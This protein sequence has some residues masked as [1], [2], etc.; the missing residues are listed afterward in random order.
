[1]NYLQ[2]VS[3]YFF[4]RRNVG[5]HKIGEYWPHLRWWRSGAQRYSRTV[6]THGYIVSTF[7][8]PTRSSFRLE[9]CPK[10]TE[11]YRLPL[12]KDRP[13]QPFSFVLAGNLL[14]LLLLRSNISALA[15]IARLRPRR[16]GS[17]IDGHPAHSQ[18]FTQ[19]SAS[20][21][22]NAV[23]GFAKSTKRIEPHIRAY[24]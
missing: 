24:C 1:M 23:R 4:S 14:G 8:I 2:R 11:C 5:Q 9:T 13:E 3:C 19:A 10:H 20:S 18:R 6:A 7:T 16:S 17:L 12:V 21:F 22:G 15:R